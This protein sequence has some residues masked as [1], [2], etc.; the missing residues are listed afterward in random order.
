MKL[1][2]QYKHFKN[3]HIKT[4]QQTLKNQQQKLKQKQCCLKEVVNDSQKQQQMLIKFI[5]LRN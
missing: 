5:K 1:K 3:V 2:N 4:Q